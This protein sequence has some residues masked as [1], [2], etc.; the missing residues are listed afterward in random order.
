[1][2]L[3]LCEIKKLHDKAYENG[4]D[5]REKMSDDLLF[6]H[7]TQWDDQHLAWSDLSYKG[8]FNVLKKAGRQILADLRLNPVQV[9]FEPKDEG[10]DDDAEFL[11]GLYRADDRLNSSIEAYDYASQDSVVCGFGA[12]EVYTEY[13]TNRAGDER[14]VIRRR[15]IPEACNT[16]FC[17]PNAKRLDKSDA[18]YWSILTSYSEDGY[19]ELASN[20]TGEDKDTINPENFSSPEQSNVFPWISQSSKYYVT[21]FYHR[22]LVKDK[23]ITL[24]DIFGQP[25]MYR[26]SD[27][28]DEI[29]DL[30]DA[31]YEIT[32]EKEIERWEVRKYIASGEEILNGEENEET[33]EREGEVIACEYI[34]I[35]P[36]YGERA[37]VEGEEVVNGITRLAKDPQRLR[38]FQM[39]YLADIVSRSPRPKPFFFPEQI[40]GLESMYDVSGSENNYPY[41]LLQRKTQNGED[42]P[43]GAVGSMPEQT[44]P[45]S[46]ML[47]LD[48]TKDAVGDV[49]EPGLPQNIADP[50][51]SGKAVALLQNQIS[52]QSYI[53]QHNMKFAKRYDGQ[54]YASMASF[55]YDAPRKAQIV[56]PDGTKKQVDV[57]QGVIDETGEI[58]MLNDLTS[59]EFEVTSDIGMN[60]DTQKEQTREQLMS[61]MQT[62]QPQDP[63][64]DM[65][66]LKLLELMDGVNVKDVREYTRKQM[67]LKGYKEPETPEEQQMLIQAQQ[68]ANQPDAMTIAAMAEQAKAQAQAAEVQRK[69][70][71]DQADSQINAGKLQIE[72]YKAQ[73]DRAEQEVD[74]YEA[75]VSIS[76]TLSEKQAIDIDNQVKTV[77]AMFGV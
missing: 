2:P 73:T 44:V 13:E 60:Y 38:N 56:L 23:V 72:A 3:T 57:M 51:L 48:L 74:A 17:D 46:L 16:A 26:N 55:V 11:D 8:E 43:R 20:L 69:A 66:S 54:V 32:D 71:K 7:I 47:S 28:I 29:D 5:N 36:V 30:L 75:G 77:N 63:L 59:I 40:Q 41:Y 76:K 67:I 22:T 31:G 52:K 24:T 18:V 19:K 64:R 37:F 9:D 35:I 21:N 68:S 39:S 53:Y 12:W 42:L 34:P 65:I 70:M 61:M 10:R 58:K 62:L 1:M 45:Q 33:G 14:Q 27:L 6:Y 25:V 49:A 15:L 50:D 4:Q